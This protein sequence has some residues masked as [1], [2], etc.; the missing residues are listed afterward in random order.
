[1]SFFFFSSRRR[2][3]RSLCNWSSDVCSSDLNR[4]GGNVTGISFMSDQLVPKRVGL[5]HELVPGA[6]RFALLVN[7]TIPNTET[8][9]R[10]SQA[11]ASAIW[12][13]IEVLT[14]STNR[15]IDLAF[16]SLV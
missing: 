12:R 8:L 2:H 11:A 5:L 16:A 13:Q 9:T 7:P 15:D 1:M 10:D 6:V 4:P 14:A 3:T